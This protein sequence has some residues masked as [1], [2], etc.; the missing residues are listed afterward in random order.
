MEIDPVTK[1]V[2]FMERDEQEIYLV[3]RQQLANC[4]LSRDQLPYTDEFDDLRNRFNVATA[5]DLDHHDVWRLLLRAS[6]AGDV[7]IEPYF[8]HLGI[9]LPPKPTAQSS[10]RAEADHP[11]ADQP[12]APVT[13]PSPPPMPPSGS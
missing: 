4:G 6:K 2:T 8:R 1:H 12:S 9:A 5:S 3:Y 13:N 11:E 10:E 7:H